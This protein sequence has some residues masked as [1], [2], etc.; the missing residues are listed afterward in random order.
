MNQVAWDI[1][2]D[3]SYQVQRLTQGAVVI[4]QMNLQQSIE[5]LFTRHHLKI[6]WDDFVAGLSKFQ[7]Q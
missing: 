2:D 5:D 3:A 6:P 7:L 1:G 4:V